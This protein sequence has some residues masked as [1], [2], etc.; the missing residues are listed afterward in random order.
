MTKREIDAC[1]VG[2]IFSRK[3]NFLIGIMGTPFSLETMTTM[4]KELRRTVIKIVIMK[5]VD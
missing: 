1:Q 4:I 5:I 2:R 3:N